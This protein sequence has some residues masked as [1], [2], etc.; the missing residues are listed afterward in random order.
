MKARY[1]LRVYGLRRIDDEEH[2]GERAAIDSARKHLNGSE[3]P[4][5][6][7]VREKLTSRPVWTG[8]LT[9]S[10][11]IKESYEREPG[12]DDA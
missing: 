12:S 1:L 11:A 10:G 5:F 3:R 7:E 8:Y 2:D 9:E 6:A 4:T